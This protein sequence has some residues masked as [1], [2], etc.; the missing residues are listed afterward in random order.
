MV[1]LCSN[2]TSIRRLMQCRKHWISLS[3]SSRKAELFAKSCYQ[4]KHTSVLR[5]SWS[6]FTQQLQLMYFRILLCIFTRSVGRWLLL[7]SCLIS[8]IHAFCLFT[9][10]LSTFLLH[11]FRRL[12]SFIYF[13][14]LFS[15]SL[16]FVLIYYSHMPYFRSPFLLVFFL[17]SVSP[18]IYLFLFGSVLIYFSLSYFPLLVLHQFLFFFIIPACLP[19]FLLAHPGFLPPQTRPTESRLV[20]QSDVWASLWR[21]SDVLTLRFGR[22]VLDLCD[23]AQ[24]FV[25]RTFYKWEI[26]L[27]RQET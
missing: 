8:S 4:T 17:S 20:C 5:I 2:N 24:S 12:I 1:R 16:T 19:S 9:L 11:S 7:Q 26:W 21:H 15:F 3:P 27:M 6:P 23:K 22:N 10:L 18:F 25:L 13:F 14:F